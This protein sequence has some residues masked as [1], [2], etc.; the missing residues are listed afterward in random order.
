MDFIHCWFPD[1][2]HN[3]I[4]PCSRSPLTHKTFCAIAYFPPSIQNNLY[5][6]LI[7]ADTEFWW[8]ESFNKPQNNWY[9]RLLTQSLGQLIFLWTVVFQSLDVMDGKH[10]PSFIDIAVYYVHEECI[11]FRRGFQQLSSAS[12]NIYSGYIWDA[13]RPDARDT[14]MLVTLT[15]GKWPVKSKFVQELLRSSSHLCQD[16]CFTRLRWQT[17]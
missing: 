2:F 1:E 5:S 12:Q 3:V 8:T 9:E 17:P 16:D 15:Y 10:C 7:L 13:R 11:W 14:G 6:H 4:P